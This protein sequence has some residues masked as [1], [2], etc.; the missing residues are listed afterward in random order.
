ML[1]RENKLDYYLKIGLITLFV[2]FFLTHLSANMALRWAHFFY[3]GLDI[4]NAVTMKVEPTKSV[5]TTQD[6]PYIHL[7]AYKVTYRHPVSDYRIKSQDY[8]VRRF[9][10]LY[11]Y[12]DVCGP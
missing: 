3:G 11:F 1:N 4:Y 9:G 8:H 12:H 5:F 2:V 6:N 10:I 7:E